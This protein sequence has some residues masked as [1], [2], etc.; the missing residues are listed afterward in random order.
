MEIRKIL[1]PTDLS[2]NAAYALPYVSSLGEKYQAEV[3]LLFVVEDVHQFDHFYGDASP[4][5][6][7]E[8]QE[9]LVRKGE[10]YLSTVCTNILSGCPLYKRHI[11][12]GDPAREILKYAGGEKVDLIVMATH[13]HGEE[14]RGGRDS[15]LSVWK[16]QRKGGE[17][18][19]C[20]GAGDQSL[21]EERM[22][23]DLR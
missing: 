13:G 20:A 22:T 11:T 12:A 19:S 10:E 7:R 17:R 5:F 4:A 23:R 16:H 2:A 18:F 6:L 1:W 21:Q 9:K 3:H 14:R 8:F 15:A